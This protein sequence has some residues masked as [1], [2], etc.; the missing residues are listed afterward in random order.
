MSLARAGGLTT[1]LLASLITAALMY[2]ASMRV[3]FDTWDMLERFFFFFPFSLIGIA[4]VTMLVFPLL[5][6]VLRRRGP[7]NAQLFA[8]T[9]AALGALVTG[10]VLIRFRGGFFPTVSIAFVAIP[11]L[12]IVGATAGFLGGY[13]FAWLARSRDEA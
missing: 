3:T 4:P 12:T 8:M 10:Y 2:F 6:W 11:L 1:L 13:I 9:G 5:H 7:V